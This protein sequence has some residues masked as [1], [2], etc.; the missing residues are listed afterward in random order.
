MPF[1]I[2]KNLSGEV[3]QPIEV[4][5]Q[6]AAMLIINSFFS[7]FFRAIALGECSIYCLKTQKRAFLGTEPTQVKQP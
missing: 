6:I 2:Y 3:Y 7:I 1:R 4:P 5:E